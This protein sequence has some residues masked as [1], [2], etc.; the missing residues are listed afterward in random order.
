MKRVLLS[1]F[2]LASAIVFAQKDVTK[3]L[4]IPVDG[5]KAEMMQ[6]LKAKGFTYK[7]VAGMEFM[8]GEF[9]GHQVNVHVVTNN[10]K[11][12][13]I[14]VSDVKEVDE[15]SIKI[16]FNNLISQFE[17]NKRY[18]TLD[19]YTIP[20][21]ED[22]RYNM[23]IKSKRYDAVFYQKPDL[24]LIDT[25]AMQNKVKEEMLIKYTKEQLEKPSE[26]VVTEMFNKYAYELF[27]K[28]LFGLLF[29]NDMV[30]TL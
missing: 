13:R 7:N 24:Q 25:L 26:E 18:T 9:N 5:T 20:D 30:N 14:M 1:V 29:Q 2:M 6:K 23:S 12:Y 17:N 10:N 19:S 28:N 11:V 27:G 3:F 16:R 8:E 15:A 22:I 4:G 21:N